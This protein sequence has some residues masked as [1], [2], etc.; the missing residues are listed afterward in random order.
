MKKKFEKKTEEEFI[1]KNADWFTRIIILR[2]KGA[3]YGKLK[4]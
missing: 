3:V 1:L 4:K 2:N